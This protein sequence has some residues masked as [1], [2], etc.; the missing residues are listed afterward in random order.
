MIADLPPASHAPIKPTRVRFKVTGLIIALGMITYLDRACIATLA[1]T[2]SAEFSLSK[3]QLGYVF[4]VFALAYAAFEIPTAWMADRSG[5]RLVLT[6]I[7]AWWSVFTIATGAAIGYYSLLVARFLFGAGEAGAWPGMAR[8]FS[9]WM[10]RSERGRAQGVFFASAHFAGGITPLIVA[11]LLSFL[12]WRMIFVCFGL[13]GFIWA[14]VWYKWFRDDPEIH[15]EVNAAELAHITAEREVAVA[16]PNGWTFWKSLLGNRSMLALCVLYFPNSFAFYFCITWLPT[17]LHE[18]HGLEA[19]SLIFFT[20]LPL[21]L[22]VFADLFGG[23]TTDWL[24]K[25]FGLRTGRC[26]VGVVTYLIAG[27]AMLATPLIH[28][29]I[30][31]ASLVALATASIMFSLAAAWGSCIDLGQENSAVVGATMNTAG[32]IGSL[33]SPLIVAYSLKWYNNWNI[34]I[35]LMGILF[36]IGAAAWCVLQPQQR[37]FKPTPLI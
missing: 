1:P 24:T 33:L 11:A 31:A 14:A 17:Y 32:Q 13:L 27:F 19:K 21:I 9:R 25:R 15:P 35:Y 20:G 34:S 6:R 36:L 5:T 23:V 3:V 12:S 30:V 18:Q 4:S 10:P 26:A 2:I 28:H 22:S 8:T 29:P 37:I 7:V 16:H